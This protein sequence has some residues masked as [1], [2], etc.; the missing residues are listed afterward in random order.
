MHHIRRILGCLAIP[1]LG[2]L[3]I[4]SPTPARGQSAP[5][6]PRPGSGM[7]FPTW[8]PLP[9]SEEEA[10]APVEDYRQRVPMPPQARKIL[11]EQMKQFLTV[12]AQLQGLLLEERF[13]EAAELAETQMGRSERG[14][15]R[16]TGYGPGRYMPVPMRRLAWG[17]HDTASEFAETARTG[18]LKASYQALQALQN[19]CVAC[20]Y[21]YTTR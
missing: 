14:R 10:A 4:H 6:P 17:M 15:H 9:V 20:H 11:Q 19:T 1:A 21:T 13:A 18:E 7:G 16:H 8:D 3:L 12:L 2:L 5:E